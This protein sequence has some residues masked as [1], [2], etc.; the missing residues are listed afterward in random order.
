M[1]AIELQRMITNIEYNVE[2]KKLTYCGSKEGYSIAYYKEQLGEVYI[3]ITISNWLLKAKILPISPPPAAKEIMDKYPD[4]K[5]GELAC[6][7]FNTPDLK[8]KSFE[9]LMA[10]L[11]AYNTDN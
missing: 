6:F 7:L 5:L 3:H 1:N 2:H 9:K 4:M 10:A 11:E 8:K